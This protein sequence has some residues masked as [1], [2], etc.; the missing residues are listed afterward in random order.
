MFPGLSVPEKQQSCGEILQ[1][2]ANLRQGS[3]LFPGHLPTGLAQPAD[4]RHGA[5]VEIPRFFQPFQKRISR[6]FKEAK[7]RGRGPFPDQLREFRL[8]LFDQL[9]GRL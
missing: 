3:S 1:A 6:G 4:I 9:F 2:D 8:K 7:V 5:A